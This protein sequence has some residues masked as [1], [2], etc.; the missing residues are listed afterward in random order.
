MN[1]KRVTVDGSDDECVPAGATLE[2][3]STGFSLSLVQSDMY[4]NIDVMT[5]EQIETKEVWIGADSAVCNVGFALDTDDNLY[6][7]TLSFNW[8]DCGITPEWSEADGV[9]KFVADVTA[10]P[11]TLTTED[12][13]GG[14]IEIFVTRTQ[15]FQ[16]ECDYAD[17][18]EIAADGITV[19]SDE[20]YEAGTM[21][22]THSWDGIFSLISFTDQQDMS[23]V[24]S[25]DNKIT[26]GNTLFNQI[27]ASSFPEELT[28]SVEY[29]NAA[30]S[31]DKTTFVNLFK[32][33]ECINDFFVF[34]FDDRAAEQTFQPAESPYDFSFQAFSFGEVL[35]S[36]SSIYLVSYTRIRIDS[37]IPF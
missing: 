20:V 14:E 27:S 25:A 29:C 10:T 37:N 30:T 24:V 13:D 6:K 22:V 4:Q 9:I 36:D 34:S 7:A 15:P 26:I 18:I 12:S 5:D 16:I 23:T 3:T 28:W 21:T 33:F 32:D 1:V 19:G 11:A 17:T 8:E 31:S 2:C 35:N